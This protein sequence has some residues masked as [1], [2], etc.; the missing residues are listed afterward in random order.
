MQHPNDGIYPDQLLLVSSKHQAKKI[1]VP[2]LGGNTI[3]RC[4]G[5][6]IDSYTSLEDHITSIF[7]SAFFHLRNLG[8]LRRYLEKE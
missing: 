1:T 2:S 4:L 5:V 3:A 8:L 7:R 6:V